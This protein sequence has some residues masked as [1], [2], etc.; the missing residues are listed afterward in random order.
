MA[1]L[2][3]VAAVAVPK[4]QNVLETSKKQAHNTNVMAIEKAAEMYFLET[5]TE[6][7]SSEI[8]ET[9]D[10]ITKNYLQTVPTYPLNDEIE[11]YTVTISDRGVIEVNPKR[12][13]IS[14]E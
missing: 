6:L 13:E 8:K 1:I 4:F 10:L 9:H 12:K 7:E 3:L 5:N 2:A 14:N 11:Y